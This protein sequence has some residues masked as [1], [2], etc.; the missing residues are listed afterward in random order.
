MQDT[1]SLR[2]AHLSV[3]SVTIANE[4]VG[5]WGFLQHE[6][7]IFSAHGRFL[8]QQLAR[9]KHLADHL[10]GKGALFGVVDGGWV[11]ALERKAATATKSCAKMLSSFSHAGLDRVQHTHTEGAHGAAQLTT[12]WDDVGGF[13]SVDHGDGDDARVHRFDVSGD[14]GL[15]GL[16]HLGRDGH[17]VDGVVRQSGMTAFALDGDAKLVAGRHHGAWAQRKLT[18]LK[19][20]PIV[21]AKDRLHGKALKETLLDHF[22]SSPT[23]LFGGLEDQI[24]SPVQ[25]LIL[26]QVLRRG[27]EH[28]GVPIVSAG[29]HLTGVHTGV[30]KGVALLHGQGVH[31]SS[32]SYGSGVV[33][34]LDH[35]HKTRGANAMVD[36]DTPRCQ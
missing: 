4:E 18:D 11:V 32:K 1:G 2:V 6:G 17:G 30:R 22:S 16:H 14:D 29:V 31:V 8:I 36:L 12:V 10:S 34:S 35:A 28:G 33:A 7:E 15:E 21:H 3:Q 26:G 19:T 9:A 23:T 13:S 5:A 25:A 20:R 27:Q 24:N